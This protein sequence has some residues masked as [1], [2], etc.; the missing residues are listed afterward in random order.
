MVSPSSNLGCELQ[1]DQP[2]LLSA[3]PTGSAAIVACPQ[4]GVPSTSA[5][6]SDWGRAGGRY[7]VKNTQTLLGVDLGGHEGLPFLPRG[8]GTA[9]SLYPLHP[10]PLHSQEQSSVG[11]SW[12]RARTLWQ[13][14]WLGPTQQL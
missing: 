14:G 4:K 5:A 11:L 3:R 6:L 1:Q 13:V 7:W 12:G 8:C 9:S 10:Q 2:K